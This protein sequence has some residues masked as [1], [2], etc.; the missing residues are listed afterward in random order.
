MSNVNNPSVARPLTKRFPSRVLGTIYRNTTGYPLYVAVACSSNVIG[1]NI[2][3]AVSD[4]SATPTTQVAEYY[5]DATVASGVGTL[6]FIVLPNDYY[7][8]YII[9]GGGNVGSWVEWY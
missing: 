6:S 9:L 8:V 5:Q 1:V 3:L 7:K 4:A 2:F